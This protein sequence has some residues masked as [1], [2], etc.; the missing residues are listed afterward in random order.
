MPNTTDDADRPARVLG[1][2]RCLEPGCG[3]SWAV[4]DRTVEIIQE[5]LDIHLRIHRLEQ[6]AHR[7]EW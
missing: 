2:Y 5:L 4:T 3:A 7:D 1:R 6:R